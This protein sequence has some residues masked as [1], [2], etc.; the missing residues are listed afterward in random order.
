MLTTLHGKLMSSA[1]WSYLL[2]L[3]QH[4]RMS[5]SMPSF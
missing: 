4:C 3:V 1:D 2:Q 5:I